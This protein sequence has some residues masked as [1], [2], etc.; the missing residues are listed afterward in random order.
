[1]LIQAWIVD[2]TRVSMASIWINNHKYHLIVD[3]LVDCDNYS[4]VSRSK[5]SFMISMKRCAG[6]DRNLPLRV[7][8][9]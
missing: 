1:M 3:N 6:A 2:N 9:P 8:M 5:L 7:T 4:A